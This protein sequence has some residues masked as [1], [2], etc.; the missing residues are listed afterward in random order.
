MQ[1]PNIYFGWILNQMHLSNVYYNRHIWVT[2][3]SKIYLNGNY[4]QK[5]TLKGHYHKVVPSKIHL[6]GILSPNI[7]FNGTLSQKDGWG[8]LSQKDGWGALSQNMC[9]KIDT[10]SQNM[11]FKGTLMPKIFLEGTLSQNT[12]EMAPSPNTYF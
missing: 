9:I 3:S 4:P 10:I 1:L 8:A 2:L 6:K 7:C 12:F 11:Y 5:Y